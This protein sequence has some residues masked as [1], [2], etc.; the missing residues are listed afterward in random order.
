MSE[1]V[2]A[3]VERHI[4]DGGFAG[5]AVIAAHHG[6]I[7][8]EYYAG[9]AAP[10]LPSGASV[11]WPLAS[12]S[13][14]YSTAMIM[15][16]VE[17]GMLTLNTPVC[18]VLP[19]FTGDGR[20]QVR[21]R[22][23]LTHTSGLI[24]ESPEM[25]ARLMAH[26]PVAELIEEAYTAPLLFAPG[27]SISY[28]DY[29]TLLAGHMAEVVTGRRFAELV[30]ELVIDPMGL[31]D[32]FMPPPTT[33]YDRI[34]HIRGVMAEDTDGAMYNS[35]YA[36]QLAHP[37]F[38]TFA[39]ARDLLA[40]TLHFTPGG[41]R[42]HTEATVQAMTRDQTGGVFGTHISLSGLSPDAPV[43]WG[44]GWA[45]QTEATPGLYCDLAS[46][47]TFGHGGASGCMLMIDPQHD[48]VIA[49]LSNTH[50]RTGRDR[51]TTRLQSILN[52]AFVAAVSSRPEG[53]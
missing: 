34:A 41:P 45:L 14:V 13:K 36:R 5:A 19:R 15:R 33:E 22:H 28:A 40:F 2:R 52:T 26:T 24:Y 20:E 23:L 10:G 29:N 12:I 53:E 7:A 47:R 4:A 43:P 35:H 3:V 49:V 27:S 9:E 46:P 30:Q 38:G 31:R 51:W 17:L 21:L 11:L 6:Q 48:V 25:E 37:A 16:L 8:V 32:T 39:T 50:V 1:H 42:I 44:L 18:H